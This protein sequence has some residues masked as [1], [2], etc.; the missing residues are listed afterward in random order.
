MGSGSRD[1]GGALVQGITEGG[2][3]YFPNRITHRLANGFANGLSNVV[4][5]FVTTWIPHCGAKIASCTI[6]VSDSNQGDTQSSPATKPTRT[7][8]AC[9]VI[10]Y[11]TAA[12][13]VAVQITHP[14]ST[15]PYSAL[16]SAGITH[17]ESATVGEQSEVAA[18]A[19]QA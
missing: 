11:S 1:P 13:A 2:R 19:Q 10:S 8:S 6:A 17:T 12:D 15:L 5:A 16:C 3:H 18:K 4:V 14:H 9:P 7:I